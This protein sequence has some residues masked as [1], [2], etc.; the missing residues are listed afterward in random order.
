MQI[1]YTRH[2]SFIVFIFWFLNSCQGQTSLPDAFA[3][4]AWVTNASWNLTTRISTDLW[5]TTIKN[6]H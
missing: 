5:I 4:A 2:F 1:R 6:T 3:D